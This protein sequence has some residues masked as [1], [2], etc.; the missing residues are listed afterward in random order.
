MESQSSLLRL[1]RYHFF[2]FGIIFLLGINYISAQSEEVTKVTHSY[3]DTLANIGWLLG[4]TVFIFL[5]YR[6]NR[7]SKD[8]KGK[9]FVAQDYEVPDNLSPIEVSAIVYQ[10]VTYNSIFAELVYLA[11]KGYIQIKQIDVPLEMYPEKIVRYSK[12]AFMGK[13]FQL[14]LLK[15]PSTLKNKFQKILLNQIFDYG[16]T[17]GGL[18]IM[19][20]SR[21]PNSFYFI[22][23]RIGVMAC[24]GLLHKGYYK[25][26]GKLRKKT[27]LGVLPS[28]LIVPLCTSVTYIVLFVAV[29]DESLR[30]I[31]FL[32]GIVVAVLLFVYISPA[33]TQKGMYAKESLLGLKQYMNVIEKDRIYFHN[34]PYKRP[35]QF[36]ELLPFAMV[37]GVDRAWVREFEGIYTKPNALNSIDVVKLTDWLSAPAPL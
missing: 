4:I 30:S 6:W 8:E 23:E 13:D 36:E 18:R 33:K 22:A 29:I 15:Q 17:E 35:E 37:L 19:H 2:G 25:Y 27:L 31:Y 20:L 26:L 11:H 28:H 32:F 3:F 16:I 12:N 7:H 34:A 9:G 5:I 24:E 21:I 14:I 10:Q 1:F